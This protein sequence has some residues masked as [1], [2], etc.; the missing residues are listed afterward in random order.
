[1]NGP[2]EDRVLRGSAGDVYSSMINDQLV[3]NITSER[4][5]V[6]V[7]AVLIGQNNE[8][9]DWRKYSASRLVNAP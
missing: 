1:M 8:A 4:R 6:A 3:A 5:F 2:V 9:C 7:A